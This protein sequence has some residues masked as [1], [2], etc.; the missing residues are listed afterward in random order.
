[1]IPH[2]RNH[3]GPMFAFVASGDKGSGGPYTWV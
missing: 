3:P 1:M 2:P